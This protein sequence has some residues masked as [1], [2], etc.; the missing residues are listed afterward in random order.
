MEIL[1]LDGAVPSAVADLLSRVCGPVRLR[2]EAGLPSRS[3]ADHWEGGDF[4]FTELALDGTVDLTSG[5]AHHRIGLLAVH[6]GQ[7]VDTTGGRQDLYRPGS[8]VLVTDCGLPRSGRALE[9]RCTVATFAPVLLGAAGTSGTQETVRVAGSDAV[10]PALGRQVTA[11]LAYLRHHV[12]SPPEV[13]PLAAATGIRH[14][15]S[16]LG[17]VLPGAQGAGSDGAD[18]ETL[19]RAMRFIEENAHRPISLP[20]IAEAAQVTARAV[21]YA[22]KRHTAGTPLGYLRRVRIGHAHR[23]LRAASPEAGS[24]AEIGA[25]WGF[26]HPGRFAAAYRAVYGFPPSRTLQQPPVARTS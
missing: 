13:D 20:E 10:D 7:F 6:G 15:A 1:R 4:S 14:L 3:G 17:A 23:E 24:V 22:F 16:V 19:Q 2:P 25:R 18:T 26:S 11:A 5:P 9:L 12:L 21:Q 8:A